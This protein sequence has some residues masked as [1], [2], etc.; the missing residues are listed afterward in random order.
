[1]INADLTIDLVKVIK[2]AAIESVRFI[3]RGDK[4]V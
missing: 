3:G 1:M 4:Y 2:A